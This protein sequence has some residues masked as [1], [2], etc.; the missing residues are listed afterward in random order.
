MAEIGN[1][2]IRIDYSWSQLKSVI[3]SKRLSLQYEESS[4]A[5][6]LFALDGAIA[7]VTRIFTGS[8]PDSNYDQ[9][10]NDLDLSDFETNYKDL[11]TNR[12]LQST[13][14]TDGYA[15]ATTS[16]TMIA[17]SDGSLIRTIQTDTSGNLKTVGTGTAGTPSGGVLTVQGVSGGTAL[18]VDG[19]AVTQPVSGTVSIGANSSVNLNQIAGTT[20]ATGNGV[21]GAGVQRV[22]IVSDN[23][24]FSVNSVQSGIWTVQPGNT[25]NTTAWFVNDSSNGTVTP[26]TVATKSSLIG[27]QF[28]TTL[29]TLTT[30]Q[31]AAIQVDSSGRIVIGALAAG[32]NTIGAVTQSGTWTVQPGN[33]ANTTPW[34]ATISHGGNSATVSAGGAL[35]VDG[36][37]VTQPVSGTLSITANSSVN[38]N[39]IAG[40]TT[41]TGNGVVGA[42]VQRVAI[43]SDNTAF[44]V[45]A[46][47]S[48]TWSIRNLDG[49]GNSLASSAT[50]P[51]G[52]EQALIVRN[53][54][55]GTQ[56]VSG[57]I[58]AN[59]GTSGSLALDATL[60]KLTVAQGAATG[61]NTQ[62][63]VG[64]V[65][66]SAAP[67][68]TTATINPFS[69]TTAGALRVDGSASTQ[70][71]SGTVSIT[72][73]SSVNLNQ[74]AGTTTATGNGVVSA[75]VQ[76]VAIASDNTAFSVNSVQSGTWTV[77]PGNTA[78]TTAWLVTSA[79]DGTVTP[80]TAAT[81]SN[82][83]GAIYNSTLP[84]ATTG[85]QI[86]LQVDANG[87]L[88][89][90]SLP[91][92]SNVI[93]AVTQSGSWS[94]SVTQATAS[95]LNATVVGSG[96]A[97]T[98]AGGVLSIQGVA[99][100][101]VI[102]VTG[103]VTAA[104][105]SIGSD[106]ATAPTS[107]TKIGGIDSSGNLQAISVT[108]T[109]L[110]GTEQAIISR[111][112]TYVAQSSGFFP[113]P[114]AD[115]VGV[116][117]VFADI[118]GRLETRATVLS[119]E[120]SFRDD[121]SGSN[122][123]TTLTGTVNFTNGSATVTGSGTAFLSELKV[124]DVMKRSTH[125]ES[126]LQF[127]D[128][129]V[130][131]TELLLANT[132]TGATSSGTAHTARWVVSTPTGGSLSQSSAGILVMGT[133]NGSTGYF[134]RDVDYGPL[135]VNVFLTISQRIASQTI[136]CGFVDSTASTPNYGAY[137]EFTGTTNTSVNCVSRSSS[138]GADSTTTT[139]TLPN[140]ATTASQN[141]YRVEV[142][143]LRA[144]FLI[145][146]VC[147]AI[148]ELHIPGPYDILDC[149]IYGT[150][151]GAAGSATT[152]A[153]E[154]VS[155][156]NF[157]RVQIAQDFVG[158]GAPTKLQV[159]TAPATANT[160][161]VFLSGT[162]LQGVQQYNAL[163]TRD[164]ITLERMYYA[165]SAFTVS[166][167]ITDVFTL[168]G[169]S[170]RTVRIQRF[171]LTGSQ[172]SGSY[173]NF[174]F[175][176]RSTA[177]SGG[178]STT[179][180]NQVNDTNFAAATATAR[181]YSAN[182]TTG[183]TVGT[184][185]YKMYIPDATDPNPGVI[186]DEVFQ[187]PIVL[188]G[189]SQVWALNFNNTTIT[190]GSFAATIWWTED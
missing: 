120:F 45:N 14:A 88:R 36:S 162:T 2:F 144:S 57:T 129:I 4:N 157:N 105:D 82:L 159:T 43:A 113:D 73:N 68:Y 47:Q 181:V 8:V 111:S 53:I 40:T 31:Q 65:A 12:V 170:T 71:V 115:T 151:T 147:V 99:G 104:N 24:A 51:A 148:H 169:S 117:P 143:A 97:G 84:T 67:T 9:V 3:D 185:E 62:A 118:T 163:H 37:A 190:G 78:N 55:S 83:T 141:K 173:V 135:G 33:T 133:A 52:A 187:N 93:G 38:L 182:P 26:G 46:A 166:G 48:G 56:T 81:K 22:A 76:R 184:M 85:Q 158:E 140:A 160:S 89:I 145:N 11:V 168:T 161:P 101:V 112:L 125:N 150:N 102:P 100:G 110:L 103:T 180:T 50:T 70:P 80:G 134:Y 13:A 139:V 126:A 95:S 172:T 176:R 123:Y 21:S 153:T 109:D 54:P 66:T 86:A 10:Q 35:K 130:S 5:Y 28:N 1:G 128:T 122:L 91:T 77:Q 142:T 75:G 114:S 132:Y 149:I 108:N 90:A 178:N 20:T 19:S 41:A 25:A 59:I 156:F 16:P 124:G 155:I 165:S 96:T 136:R 189:T 69:L 61:T 27:G 106:A 49:S 74:I 164:A 116:T 152:I 179:L 154:A 121:F 177:N 23:T 17:G 58:T 174:D 64:A 186:L 138:A 92:G 44:S 98:P 34:L 29:P 171:L 119:D 30:G 131:D 39:Q 107:S 42:G 18:K 87:Q 72:S 167:G 79:S 183:T 137:F 94:A 6:D 60:A 63:L 15:I 188:R 127:I 32:S 175:T 7:Y 146:D